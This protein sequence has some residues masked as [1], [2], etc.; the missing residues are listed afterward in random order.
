MNFKRTAKETK[1]QKEINFLTACENG[2]IKNVK[3]LLSQGRKYMHQLNLSHHEIRDET[4]EKGFEIASTYA[5]LDVIRCLIPFISN[6][7]K[8]EQFISI[9]KTASSEQISIMIPYVRNDTLSLGIFESCKFQNRESVEFFIQNE[10]ADLEEI[11]M[12]LCY[13]NSLDLIQEYINQ[14]DDETLF[15]GFEEACSAF[16]SEKSSGNVDLILY[17]VAFGK[18]KGIDLR[19]NEYGYELTQLINEAYELY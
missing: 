12:S 7:I 18:T 6:K 5:N 1:S 3:K 4:L 19:T 16:I 10:Y 17:L 8:E 13:C 15:S 2:D 11:F 9:C 14:I